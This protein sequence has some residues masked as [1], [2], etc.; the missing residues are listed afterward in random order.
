MKH[1]YNSALARLDL[2]EERIPGGRARPFQ[3]DPNLRGRLAK[4]ALCCATR[5]AVQAELGRVARRKLSESIDV[6]R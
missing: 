1:W 3:S 5:Q 4:T 2:E 6:F